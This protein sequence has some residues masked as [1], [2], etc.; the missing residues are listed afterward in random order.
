VPWARGCASASRTV[1]ARPR[2]W[3]QVSSS[4][5]WS[6]RSPLTSDRVWTAPAGQRRC[7]VPGC[8]RSRRFHGVSGP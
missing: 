1:T 6:P 5:A 4:T 3:S 8:D 2:R 7:S